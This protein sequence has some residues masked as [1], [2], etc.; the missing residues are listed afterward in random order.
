M[1]PISRRRA[2]Q[3]GGL[4]LTGI[5]L[6]GTGLAWPG[7]SVL[8]PHTGARLSEPK[9]LRGEHGLLR[10]RLESAEGPLA[11]AGREATAYGY[12]GG[13]PGPTLRLRRGDRLQVRLV[14]RLQ[15]VNNLHVHGL[16]VSPEGN[17]DN[18]F[19]A[20]QPSELSRFPQAA[21]QGRQDSTH[22]PAELV[23]PGVPVALVGAGIARGRTRLDDG[24]GEVRVVA[25]VPAESTRPVASPAARQR[26][27]HR[28][29]A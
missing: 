4:G 20:V 15:A 3:L 27:A 9:V 23:H 16:N 7:D 24:A 13:L 21:S 17:G 5:A 8:D 22:T 18:V 26:L 10:V 25:G 28:A 1:Q 29:G 19:V 12:N 14:N 11:I 6:G 2:L